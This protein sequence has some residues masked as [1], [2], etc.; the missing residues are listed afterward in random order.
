LSLEVI[1]EAATYLGIGIVTLVHTID[2]G[3]VILGGAMNFGGHDSPV[4]RQFLQRV[5][6]IFASRA[7]EIVVKNTV[8]DY[9]S[10]GGDA[11][12]IGAA[13]VARAKFV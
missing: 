5:R 2:P 1:L 11:G 3:A 9:A 13:G 7:F 6:E 10:L 8:I 12:Y 4:G